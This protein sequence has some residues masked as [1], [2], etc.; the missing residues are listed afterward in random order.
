METKHLSEDKK[1]R[2]ENLKK[3]R[4]GQINPEIGT[5]MVLEAK[6]IDRISYNGNL[7]KRIDSCI[8]NYYN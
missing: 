7:D 6:E 8:S 2:F 4:E 1:R 5:K 3:A